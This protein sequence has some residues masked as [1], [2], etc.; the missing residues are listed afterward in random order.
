[1]NKLRVRVIM[2]QG[3]DCHIQISTDNQV[4]FTVKIFSPIDLEPQTM[5]AME[6]AKVLFQIASTN[7]VVPTHVLWKKDPH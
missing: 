1:M 5:L 2:T 3:K 6:Q 7:F 4:W